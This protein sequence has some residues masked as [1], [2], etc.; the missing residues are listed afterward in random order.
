[1]QTK[2]SKEIKENKKS[3]KGPI[4]FLLILL[5]IGIGAFIYLKNNKELIYGKNIYVRCN[6]S[7]AEEE[8][9]ASVNVVVDLTLSIS[10]INA[11]TSKST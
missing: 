6:T 4:I 3:K 8:I 5:L 10:L 7:Y 11:C 9:D 1:M 2:I